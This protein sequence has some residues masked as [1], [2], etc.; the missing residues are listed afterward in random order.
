MKTFEGL[1]FANVE[2]NT[3]DVERNLRGEEEPEKKDE[4][5]GER[6]K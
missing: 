6:L 3:E 1:T 5:K 2:T 4:A